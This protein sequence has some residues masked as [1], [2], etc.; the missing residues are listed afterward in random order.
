MTPQ[1]G[2]SPRQFKVSTGLHV[3][4]KQ[5]R[6]FKR[7]EDEQPTAHLSPRPSSKAVAPYSP[8]SASEDAHILVTVIVERTLTSVGPRYDWYPLA[9]RDEAYFHILMSSVA[10]HAAYLQQTEQPWSIYYHRGESIRLLN[11]RIQREDH[12]EGTL[13]CICMFSQQESFE[14]RPKTTKSH[15]DGLVYLVQLAGGINSPTIPAKTRR[16]IYL[17]DLSAAITL[18]CKP[19]LEP[20]LDL[21]NLHIFFG[22]ASTTTITHASEFAARLHNFTGSR[23]SDQATAI[24]WGL[25]NV[26]QLHEDIHAGRV[27]AD[28]PH[29]SDL[30]F[31]DRV[32]VLER[33]VHPLWYVE[34]PATE[35]HAVFR[36]FGLTCLIYI[37]TI[38]RELP[39]ELG[40]NPMLASRIKA[41][42][43]TCPELNVLL[44]TFQDLLL[45]QMF[46]CGR[47]A[48][49]RDRPWFASQ[50][51]KIL[52]IRKLEN[53]EN[54]LKAADGFLW[55]ESQVHLVP[56]R[57]ENSTSGSDTEVME[58]DN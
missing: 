11:E 52:L 17:T 45:W 28:T 54:I 33:L 18:S 22:Q 24:I 13:N 38:L 8:T 20:T 23:L 1:A 41:A 6:K 5:Q 15:I 46:I 53:A 4:R 19:I 57:I 47:V 48:D 10:S 27:L 34:D 35:Q 36:T 42:L 32:E 37:Y 49:E 40:M 7:R 30:Q 14:G 12:D 39:K 21:S 58:V 16:H 9:V 44:A 43:E 26:S 2:G 29:A 3:R 50:A 55:P 56:P 31:T 25:R 51:T